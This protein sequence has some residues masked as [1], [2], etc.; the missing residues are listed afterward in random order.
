MRQLILPGGWDGGPTCAIVGREARRLLSVLR[1]GP[2]DELPALG[3]DG[4]RYDCVIVS[5]SRSELRLSVREAA[6]Q[7]SGYLP[8]VRGA[9]GKAQREGVA[10]SAALG[11]ADGGA[12]AVGSGAGTGERAPL[13]RLV[14]AVGLLKGSR[15]D[16]AVRAAAEAGVTAVVPLVTERAQAR[17]GGEARMERL[18]R[19]AAEALGQS[20]SPVA[21]RVEGPMD[22]DSFLA[23]Y[24]ADGTRRLGLYFHEAP[25]AQ[26]SLHRYCSGGP[27]EIAAFV[28]PE[29]GLGDGERERLAAAGYRPAWLGPAVLRAETAAVFAVASLRIVCLERYAWSVR[30]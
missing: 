19:V 16:E 30:E 5:A 10:S 11:A 23:A 8:D 24:P 18:R 4:R 14:L 12:T 29:G 1:L 9:A 26:A 28:G 3:P 15:L 13:P 2:G 7:G 21:T 27:E 6:G 17:D 22:L 20:G 25:L